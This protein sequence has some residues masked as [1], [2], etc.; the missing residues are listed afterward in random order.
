[1]LWRCGQVDRWTGGV[2]QGNGGSSA[3]AVLIPGE[4]YSRAVPPPIS[5]SIATAAGCLPIA[6][7]CRDAGQADPVWLKSG[8]LPDYY[9]SG[10]HYQTDGWLSASS[11][12][13]RGGSKRRGM[14]L[15]LAIPQG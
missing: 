14:G 6:C 4:W 1:M 10:F 7:C 3:S 9:T 11:G 8:L 5:H 13:R 12:E 15:A 2:G